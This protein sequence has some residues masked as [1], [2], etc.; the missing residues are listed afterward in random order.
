MRLLAVLAVLMFV[1]VTANA[2]DRRVPPYAAP[3]PPLWPW[4]THPW[5]APV[6]HDQVRHKRHKGYRHGRK[7]HFTH[8][9]AHKAAPVH[10][11]RQVATEHPS[12]HAEHQER[13][14]GLGHGLVT[15]S[16]AAGPITVFYAVADKFR[17]LIA[18]FAAAGYTPH[19]VGCF[20]AHGHIR[21]SLHHSGRACDFDQTG[22]NATAPFM[23]TQ[24][25]HA[26]V[27][28]VGLRDGCDFHSRRDCG[29]VDAGSVRQAIRT[30][31]QN[32]NRADRENDNRHRRQPKAS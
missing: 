21:N 20:A 13:S 2:A 26:L 14:F 5:L 31:H 11:R 25:A 18:L 17:E 10:S 7:H 27:A 16:T 29:H 22:W 15:V 1:P 3:T 6:D 32:S 9:A 4:S 8:V 19:H 24:Q 28:S 12:Q 30:K 23:Y